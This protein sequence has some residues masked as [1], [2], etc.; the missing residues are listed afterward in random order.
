MHVAAAALDLVL[1]AQRELG[2]LSYRVL[3]YLHD[4]DCVCNDPRS[5]RLDKPRLSG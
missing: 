5:A 3:A 4:P 2:R 1:R